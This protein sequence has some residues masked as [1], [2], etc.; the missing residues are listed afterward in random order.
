MLAPPISPLISFQICWKASQVSTSTNTKKAARIDMD[1]RA[2]MLQYF[3]KS[4]DDSANVSI[5]EL[6][7]RSWRLPMAGP[8]SQLT[9]WVKTQKVKKRGKTGTKLISYSEYVQGS[10]CC[11]HTG[12]SWDRE[13]FNAEVWSLIFILYALWPFSSESVSSSTWAIPGT[14]ASSGAPTSYGRR[15][16]RS[17]FSSSA[18]LSTTSVLWPAGGTTL[19][20]SIMIGLQTSSFPST[21]HHTTPHPT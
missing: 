18:A 14:C 2:K 21:T 5:E 11:Y 15:T 12:S 19:S 1:D 4:N 13:E 6:F 17:W 16:L 8:R 10:L 9:F 3:A 20:N 7:Q